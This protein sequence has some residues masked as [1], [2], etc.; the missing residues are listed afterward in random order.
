MYDVHVGLHVRTCT[1]MALKRYCIMHVNIYEKYTSD[2]IIIIIKQHDL[3]MG[4][5]EVDVVTVLYDNID[6]EA[7]VVTLYAY[8]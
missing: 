7:D 2:K 5:E 3:W 1:F 4:I 6:E 8:F